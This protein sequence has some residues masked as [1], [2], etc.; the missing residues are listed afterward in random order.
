MKIETKFSNGDRVWWAH[1]IRGSIGETD[2]E[3]CGGRGSLAVEGKSYRMQCPNGCRFGKFPVYGPVPLARE[4][5]IGQVRVSITDSPGDG[6]SVFSN[7]GPQHG[8]EEQYMCIESGIG[9]GS[10]YY[11]DDL[12]ATEAEALERAKFKVVEALEYQREEKERQ[13]VEVTVPQELL[14]VQ[15]TR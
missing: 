13:R 12:F 1:T 8:R 3:E 4:M 7:Y 11:A 14:R 9:S 6:D 5:T 10:L 2:C 15:E